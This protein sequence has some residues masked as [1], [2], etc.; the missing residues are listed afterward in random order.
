MPVHG[1]FL[2][3]RCVGTPLNL[4]VRPHLRCGDGRR[5]SRLRSRLV[6]GSVNVRV[7]GGACMAEQVGR[8]R[9][10]SCSTW[11]R[12]GYAL[13]A[14]F[15]SFVQPRRGCA[16]VTSLPFRCNNLR[17]AL[18]SWVM[19]FVLRRSKIHRVRPNRPVNAD[20]PVQPVYL[21]SVGGGAPVT[22]VR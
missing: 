2:G 1:F 10:A 4:I 15:L 7:A 5:R 11:R 19:R 16:V 9:F 8:T 3:G 20:A 12:C 21:A 22:L 17:R 6:L 13:H 18:S 14:F